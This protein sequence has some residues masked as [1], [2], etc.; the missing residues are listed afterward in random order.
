MAKTAEAARR[1]EI[2]I[3]KILWLVEVCHFRS[4]DEREDRR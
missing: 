2:C 1:E 4:V 3:L